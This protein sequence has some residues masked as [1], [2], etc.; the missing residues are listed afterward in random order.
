[1]LDTPAIQK[2]KPLGLSTDESDSAQSHNRTIAPAQQKAEGPKRTK[3]GYALRDD[4]VKA[5]KQIALDNDRLLY[6]VMEEAIEQ[7]LERQKGGQPIAPAPVV[8][9]APVKQPRWALA[10]QPVPGEDDLIVL[11]KFADQHAV[12]RNEAEKLWKMGM[13]AGV[14]KVGKGVLLYPNGLHDFWV[15][16]HNTPGFLACDDCPHVK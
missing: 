9:P 3:R 10:H 8:E 11:W 2:G 12:A 1:M 15:Q 6:E 5:C 16:F 13:I 7:Y 14:R 4:L